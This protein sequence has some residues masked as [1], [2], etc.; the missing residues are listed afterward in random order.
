MLT[1]GWTDGASFITSRLSAQCIAPMP[2]AYGALLS[3]CAARIRAKI[4]VQ[5]AKPDQTK[6]S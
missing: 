3:L 6:L 1:I 4:I 5:N 2:A